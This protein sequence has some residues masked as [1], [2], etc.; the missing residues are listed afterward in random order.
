M[1]RGK[2]LKSLSVT[3]RLEAGF[4]RTG[5]DQTGGDLAFASRQLLICPIRS[6]IPVRESVI[7]AKQNPTLLVLWPVGARKWSE[8]MSE[9]YSLNGHLDSAAAPAM[10]ADLLELR[11]RPLRIDASAVFFAG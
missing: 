2:R 10:S 8:V 7:P 3:W 5:N 11:G 6:Q 9:I 4:E 1:V